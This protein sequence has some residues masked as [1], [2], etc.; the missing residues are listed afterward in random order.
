MKRINNNIKQYLENI[1]KDIRVNELHNQLGNMIMEL[2]YDQWQDNIQ[3]KRKQAHYLSMEFLVGRSIH[4]NL[5]NMGIYDKVKD[6]LAEKGIDINILEDIEDSAL[7]N[8][9][10][11]R[12]AACFLDSAAT[13]NIPLNGYG[14]RYKYGLFKQA[15]QNGNQKEFPDDWAK[16]GDPFSIRRDDIVKTIKYKDH[17]VKA[18]AYDVPIIGYG[19]KRIGLMRLWQAEG[20][21]KISEYLYPDDSTYEG[22]ALRL[23]QEYFFS[24]A[25]VQDVIDNYVA[26]HGEDFEKFSRF[27]IFQLNDTHP[28][29]A[30]LELIRILD[31]KYNM[32]IPQA[33]D[34]ARDSFAYTNHTIMNE[35]LERWDIKLFNSILPE[36]TPYVKYIH[37]LALKEYRKI[38]NK[39]EKNAVKIISEKSINMARLAVYISKSVNG[40]AQLHTEIIKKDLFE[41]F[42]KLFPNKINN[43][44]N[45][46][47]QRRWLMLSNIGLSSFITENIGD[48]WI[49]NLE[50]IKKLDKLSKDDKTI[51]TINNIKMENKNILK[52]YIKKKENIEINTDSIFD[53]Q[54]KRIHEYKRQLMNAFSILYI[55]NE[56]KEGNIKDFYPTTFIFGGKSAGG[57]YRAKAI[58]KFI[59]EIANM[60]NQ[61]DEV[62]HLIKVVFVENY[63]VSYAEKLIPATDCS[64]QISLAGTEASGTGNM[65]F[66]LNGA[67]TL[68]T[69]DGANIEIVDYAGEQN[70]Y[71]FGMTEEQ[72]NQEKKTYNSKDYLAKNAKIKCLIDSLIDGTF[73]DN[74]SGQFKD[75]YKSLV[76]EGDK[77]MVILD[78]LDYVEAKLRVNRD[79]KDRIAFG[80][81]AF[82][83][84]I[85]AGYFSS[86]R[87][88]KQYN[89]EI[90]QIKE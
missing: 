30:I 36:L 89:Q 16:Y 50:E 45:G 76:E 57:Y 78:L 58:I 83:N 84:I 38:L 8:G 62:S 43:K 26:I 7:G 60:I 6:I 68:G 27:N 65:K 87:T 55:Y 22:K 40:V 28:V 1:N 34:I 42:N 59:N 18:V 73:N 48:K 9:G 44:T 71:I 47:T 86:D 5:A 67:V 53:V 51:E 52:E 46:I 17:S 31:K 10:L 19:I 4:N 79:Y 2:I 75:I 88:I 15:F 29:V 21:A 56:I 11:G 72:V 41:V 70:N 64:E 24:S 12:L 61:D 74:G 80:R 20:D 85:N 23:K 37:K 35:A 69:L 25:S 32:P 33:I 14:I 39:K 3:D 49:I 63:N 77:Y 54:I 82:V 90:W 13:H 81:K 66:M